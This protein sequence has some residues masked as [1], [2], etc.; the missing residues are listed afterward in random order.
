VSSTIRAFESVSDSH[1]NVRLLIVGD[2]PDNDRLRRIA[3]NGV[4][5]QILFTGWLGA[6]SAKVAIY[7]AADVVV[8]ASRSEGFPT[9]VAEAMACGTPVV[10]TDTGAVSDLVRD[11]ETGW[12][13]DNGEDQ[14]VESQ[15]A[16]RLDAALGGRQLSAM[17]DAARR[18]ALCE[19][20]PAVV[21]AQLSAVFATA[22]TRH[23]RAQPALEPPRPS[24]APE[25]PG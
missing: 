19:V 14:D 24:S 5:N 18:V 22:T 11:G 2:G 1:P 13:L 21:G 12:L 16:N 9:V 8:L 4:G 23:R 15:L 3:A 20:S 25:G 6:N 7:N 10:A 17:R